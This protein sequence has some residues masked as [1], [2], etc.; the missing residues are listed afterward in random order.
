METNKTKID[1][2][3]VAAMENKEISLDELA[4]TLHKVAVNKGFW[5]ANSQETHIIFYLKQIAMIH[6]EATEVL[7]AI[8]KEE[9][10]KKVVEELADIIIRVLDLYAGLVEDG[11][12]ESSLHE[13]LLGKMETNKERPQMHG[14]LA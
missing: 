13:V 7:E 4:F 11:A 6:S 14:V 10:E 2:E 9:G 1:Q 3:S 12:V 5:D 8:R